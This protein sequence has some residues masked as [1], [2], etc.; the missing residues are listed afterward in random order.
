VALE[1]SFRKAGPDVDQEC[2]GVEKTVQPSQGVGYVYP[3]RACRAENLWPMENEI[4]LESK[5]CFGAAGQ[6]LCKAPSVGSHALAT[7]LEES[8]KSADR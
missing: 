8:G 1:E 7:K 2:Y 6:G 4:A 3:V 5:R